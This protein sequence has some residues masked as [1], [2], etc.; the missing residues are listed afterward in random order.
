MVTQRTSK[1]VE[2]LKNVETS[3]NVE[4][5]QRRSKNVEE[6]HVMRLKQYAGR[7]VSDT[8][9]VSGVNGVEVDEIV[10]VFFYRHV[11]S[12]SVSGSF[13]TIISMESPINDIHSK[14]RHSLFLVV[15]NRRG[16]KNVFKAICRQGQRHQ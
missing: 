4:E 2:T 16:I 15:E 14:V 12:A 10:D 9:D 7:R 6:R 3:K 1:N 5:R 11:D 13:L 8:N